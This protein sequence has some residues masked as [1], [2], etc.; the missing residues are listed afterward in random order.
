MS[1]S[2]EVLFEKYTNLYNK[3]YKKNVKF[4][5]S[6]SGFKLSDDDYYINLNLI[7]RDWMNEMIYNYSKSFNIDKKL[8]NNI[9]MNQYEL[10]DI[11]SD[12]DEIVK[13]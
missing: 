13:N 11:N 3:K 9:F 6:L 8:N 7:V 1:S 5:G 10:I 12:L 2:V 4:S